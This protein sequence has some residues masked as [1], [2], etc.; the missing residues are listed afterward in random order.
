M[1][2]WALGFDLSL[3]APAAVALP[4]DW[5][6]GDWKRVGAWLGT[7]PKVT[8]DDLQGQAA[9]MI[10]IANWAIYVCEQ[11]P[12]IA[13]AYVEAYGYAPNNKNSS[14]VMESGG[15]VKASVYEKCDGL[16]LE[17]VVA[18][19]ARKLTFGFN[20]TKPRYDVKPFV[21]DTLARFGAPS[22]W[23]ENQRDAY[24]VA[25]A[26]LSSAGGKI[27]TLGGEPAELSK[28]PL[29]KKKR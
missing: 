4:L 18:S 2:E 7:Q 13:V 17:P 15:H 20:P 29:S 5:R 22:G 21:R 14:R 23:D 8:D 9:R 3:T 10:A 11:V 16:I 1:I 28:K 27:L 19:S 25:Q 24:V 12:R 26:A 6:P